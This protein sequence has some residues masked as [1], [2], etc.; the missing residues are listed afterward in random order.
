[1]I[2]YSVIGGTLEQVRSVGATVVKDAS[3]VGVIFADLT[4]AQADKLKAMGCTVSKVGGLKAAVVPPVPVAAAP[5]YSPEQLVWAA[6]MEDLRA[7]TTPPLY[8][9][10][11]NLALIGTGI[12]ETHEKVKGHVVYRKNYT[13]DPMVDGFDH[14]TGCSGIA[15]AVA[16]QCNILN[17]KALGDN[18]EGTEEEAVLAISDCISLQDTQPDIAPTVIN[19]SLGSPDDGNPNNVMRV[20]CRAAIREG[21]WVIAACGNSGPGP[22]TI[23]NPACERYVAAVG[24]CSYEPFVISDWSSRGPTIEGLVKP[25]LLMFGEDIVMASS[26]S[27]TATVAKSGTSFSTPFVSAMVILAQ[28]AILRWVAYEPGELPG[29]LPRGALGGVLT[30]EDMIDTHLLRVG[31]KP[32]GAPAGKDNGYGYGLPLGSLVAQVVRARPAMD[33]SSVLSAVVVIAMMGMMMRSL[34]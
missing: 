13:S 11:M 12:R 27:D 26:A 6:G 2:R 10:G 16:P 33:V 1:M 25:D 21:I 3:A 8:G 9:Q 20:A 34:R 31:V 29:L 22:G 17:L 4:Q 23:L 7:L 15:L 28:E 14:E 19:L 30:V 24:S 32:T 18:G 5:T